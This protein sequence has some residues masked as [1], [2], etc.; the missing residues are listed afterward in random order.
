MAVL[1]GRSDVTGA[2]G[3][4]T[5][6]DGLVVVLV[7]L[8]V[9]VGGVE[10]MPSLPSRHIGFVDATLGLAEG[11][12]RSIRCSG[13]GFSSKP[14]A[15]EAVLRSADSERFK[16]LSSN[17][18]LVGEVDRDLG[19]SIGFGVPAGEIP[20]SLDS[21]RLSMPCPNAGFAGELGLDPTSSRVFVVLSALAFCAFALAMSAIQL[22][23]VLRGPEAGF[24]DSGFVMALS[25]QVDFVGLQRFDGLAGGSV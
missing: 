14:G 2:V 8:P 3:L 16:G 25:N 23:W 7:G 24:G 9:L 22:G 10:G 11:N 15:G 19:I 17:I 1:E 4:S 6:L 5:G 20:K 21:D 13:F 18:L 12:V